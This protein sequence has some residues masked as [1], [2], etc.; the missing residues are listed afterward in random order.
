MLDDEFSFLTCMGDTIRIRV[1]RTGPPSLTHEQ[2]VRARIAARELRLGVSWNVAPIV[3][4]VQQLH[5]AL[6]GRDPFFLPRGTDPTIQ[7]Q[8]FFVRIVDEL[9]LALESGRLLVV[10]GAFPLLGIPP[11]L[12][13]TERERPT[14][15]DSPLPSIARPQPPDRLTFFEVRFVD[16]IG[17]PIGALEVELK[18]GKAVET[19]PTNPAGVAT[20][21]DVV[22]VSGSVGVLSVEALAKL[23][24]PRWEERRL[25]NPPTGV[26]TKSFVLTGAPI[27]NVGLK[28]AVPNTVVITPPV[29]KLFVELWDKTGSTRLAGSDYTITGP[30]SFSGTT[31]ES[32]RLVHEDVLPGDYELSVEVD[33]NRVL[34]ASDDEATI[35]PDVR[36]FTSPLV[37]LEPAA[38][39]P[40]VRMLASLRTLHLACVRGALFDTNKTFL[41]P[42]AIDC[43]KEIRKI[44]ERS[45]PS[46][47]LVVG[48]A[49]TTAQPSINDPLSLERAERTIAYLEDDVENWLDQYETS[50]PESKRWGEVEDLAMIEAMPDF[51][52]KQADEES[53]RWFQRTRGLKVDGIAGPQTRTHLI[54]EYMA[55]DGASLSEGDLDITPT[56]H[57]CGENFPLDE[58]GQALD[59]EPEDDKEDA[60]DRRVELFFFNK[61]FGIE[62]APPGKN[63]GPGSTQYPEWRKRAQSTREF[64]LGRES[65]DSQVHLQLLTE[66]GKQ[67]LSDASFKL[68]L[69]EA[70]HE[71]STNSAGILG[72]FDA[73]PGDH[74]L[75][76][77]VGDASIDLEAPTTTRREGA[78][79]LLVSGAT[80]SESEANEEPTDFIE[81]ELRGS[82]GEPL[83]NEQ[84]QLILADGSSR[85]GELDANG[86]ARIDGVA[87]GEA[88]ITF[89]R[90]RLEKPRAILASS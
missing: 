30:E 64:V 4:V 45:D 61:E 24:D 58:T 88:R 21:E 68:E 5:H 53:V 54:T 47:L 76:I 71:G 39:E 11:D 60:L 69:P 38:G 13:L 46:E 25:G 48:H 63:S 34:G 82:D 28:P 27:E 33:V 52:N 81:V 40:E 36:Q 26:N 29:G 55:L 73:P 49:D 62:P 67:I 15:P 90:L 9:E 83:A 86:F 78:R 70:T 66:D 20:L 84:F 6:L 65:N 74:P 42:T 44:Y 7:T 22:S 16:E 32:G 51:S 41:L 14:L 59:E 1:V 57:G 37:V 10:E 23:L 75:N 18:A 17:Q 31:D 3:F 85:D 56:A 77:V 12:E 2:R 79:V 72:P 50:V 43:L 35:E 87:P 8:S 19:V 89:P 80:S